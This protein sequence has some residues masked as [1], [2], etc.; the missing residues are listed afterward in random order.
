MALISFSIFTIIKGA[1]ALSKCGAVKVFVAKNGAA[2]IAKLGVDGTIAATAAVAGTVG[3]AVAIANLPK[4]TTDGFSKIVR[5]ILEKK[6][7]LFFGGLYKVSSAYAT[8]SGFTED[9]QGYVNSLD[10]SADSKLTITLTVR[11][12]AQVIADKI[13]GRINKP[14]KGFEEKLLQRGLNESDYQKRIDSIYHQHTDGMMDDYSIVLGRAGRIY[15]DITNYN[16]Q[17]NLVAATSYDHFLVFCIAG[18]ILSNKTSLDC[19]IGISQDKLAHD[20]TENIFYYLRS[21]GK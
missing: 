2:I 19:L 8:A 6:S 5:G 7:A 13:E 1:V 16:I 3:T 11:E 21:I 12:T 14:V 20:I 9:F 15:S 10:I 4:E 17:S 18:W